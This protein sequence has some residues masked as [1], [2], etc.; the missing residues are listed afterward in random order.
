MRTLHQLYLILWMS[1]KDK[2]YISGLCDEINHLH[3][4]NDKPLISFN[5]LQELKNHF[6]FQKPS[7]T[8]NS[9]FITS[10]TWHGGA[11][12]WKLTEDTNPIN[13]KAFVKKMIKITKK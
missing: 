10:P 1:I 5:E 3:F 11:W 6:Q 13:R 4:K 7:E 8:L 12:W 9:E 2:D